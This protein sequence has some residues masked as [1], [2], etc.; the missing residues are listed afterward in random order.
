MAGGRV[1]GVWI[2]RGLDLPIDRISHCFSPRE[3]DARIQKGYSLTALLPPPTSLPSSRQS[4]PTQ[5][6]LRQSLP[7]QV[8]S[9]QL[10]PLQIPPLP[11]SGPAQPI[12]MQLEPWHWPLPPVSQL[13][14]TQPIF[15][16]PK[17]SHTPSWQL[18]PM[19][20]VTV[21]L[22]PMQTPPLQSLPKQPKLAQ[23]I[24]VHLLVMLRKLRARSL[25]HRSIGC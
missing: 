25:T 22:G 14:P 15:K 4:G 10:G 12:L 11:Q 16:Q 3:G 5:A 1:R 13:R 17:P 21:Q 18:D 9:E 8:S 20:P 2:F 19:Q 24:P 7:V 23:R 6:P